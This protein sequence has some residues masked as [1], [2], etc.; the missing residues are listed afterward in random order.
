[1]QKNLTSARTSI[2]EY[3]DL[4]NSGDVDEPLTADYP[5]HVLRIY[6]RQF[7]QLPWPIWQMLI[8]REHKLLYNPIAKC[9]S[10]SLRAAIVAMSGI[11]DEV[12]ALPLDTHTTG[13]QVGDLPR[14]QAL[15]I[16]HDPEYVKFTVIRNPFQ[17]LVSAYLEK[18]VVNRLD[19]GNQFHTRGVISTVTGRSL[20][21]VDFNRSISF[22]EFVDY[23]VAQRPEQLDPHW[24]PQYLYLRSVVHRIF[25]L[26][27]VNELPRLLRLGVE[28]P[29][30]NVT[31][32][33]ALQRVPQAQY[34]PAPEIP[35]G[36]VTPES[37]IDERIRKKVEA[38]YA[39]DFTLCEA[40]AQDR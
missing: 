28:V 36:N 5:G 3:S 18:F 4:Y 6:K 17:R 29:R 30:Y 9:G 24:C 7:N 11:P 21:Q 32:R 12:K 40:A 15:D 8:V 14:Q 31:T 26:E 34:L 23:I 10:S 20:S 2:Y 1:M 39:L 37:F 33:K 25:R 27:D 13:L 35:H 38:Y 16:L 22:A 19:A